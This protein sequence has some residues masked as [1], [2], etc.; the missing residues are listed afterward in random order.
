MFIILADIKSNNKRSTENIHPETYQYNPIV[1]QKGMQQGKQLG[2]V[3][4]QML[5]NLPVNNSSFTISLS[6]VYVF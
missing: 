3:A 2:R 1:T 6:R 5:H 4:I